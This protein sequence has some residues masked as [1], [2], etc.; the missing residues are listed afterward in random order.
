MQKDMHCDANGVPCSA[1]GLHHDRA[2]NW[3][4]A[5][6]KMFFPV[7]QSLNGM[8]KAGQIQ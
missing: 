2:L 4:H 1:R 7:R 5:P 6:N 3:C 8:T